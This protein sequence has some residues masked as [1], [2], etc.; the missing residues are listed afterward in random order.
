MSS[1]GAQSSCLPMMSAASCTD[2]PYKRANSSRMSVYVMLRIEAALIGR[3]P[4]RA[5]TSG[6]S[7]IWSDTF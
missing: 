4:N 7:A 3:F 5:N 6:S 1:C 2:V